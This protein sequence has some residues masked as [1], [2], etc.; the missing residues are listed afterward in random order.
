M[1]LTYTQWQKLLK[2]ILTGEELIC[3]VYTQTYTY[4]Q[5]ATALKRKK[6]SDILNQ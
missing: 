3:G 5:W 1:K 4:I 2:F 6:N